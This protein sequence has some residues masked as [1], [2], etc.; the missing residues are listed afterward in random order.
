[1][2]R[3]DHT[4]FQPWWQRLAA[5]W[6]LGQVRDGES[7][8]LPRLVQEDQRLPRF[9]RQCPTTMVAI[10]RLRLLAW[11]KLNPTP[12]RHYF[13]Y[14]P[15][16]QAAYIGANL[17]KIEAGMRSM[18]QL[19]RHL[20]QH[21][22]LIWALGFPL[23]GRSQQAC[24]FDPEA[25]LPTRRHFSHMLRTLDNQELQRLLDGQVSQLKML[26]PAEFGQM[27]SLDTKHILAFVKENN[28]KA[29]IKEGRYDKAQQP[30][31]DSD[32]KLGC[33]R[34]H[35]QKSPTKEGEAASQKVSIGEY[36]WGYASGVVAT[37]I[38]DWGE[39]VLAELTQTFDQADIS[40]FFPLMEAVER[41]LG[42]RPCYGAFDAAFDAFYVY[43]YFDS[44]E[45]DGFAAVPYSEKGGS[46]RRAFSAEGL[47]L[48]AAS[49]PMP[50]KFTFHD[51]T[52][53]L[54]PHVRARYACPLLF[55]E[56]NGQACPVAH[57][58]WAKGGC[59]TTM[60]YTPGAQIRHQLDRQSQL[61]QTVYKQRTATERINSQAVHLGIERPKL[62]NQQ[63]ITNTNTLIYLLINLRA[64]ER[65]LA[66][67]ENGQTD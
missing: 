4:I 12:A 29:Y 13:G 20:V 44:E 51:R 32:C 34:R 42:F 10:S 19:R 40:Y 22:G 66:K 28:P 38:A 49:L 11:D 60:A 59:L 67:L 14:T 21:P 9:V 57:K 17:L 23:Y 64:M 24:G 27:V 30:R 54:I 50:L 15:V 6:P 53:T 46:T 45:H 62:R 35:N 37:K 56:A 25:S 48:C 33:K 31:G 47:P 18:G 39:F 26:L 3:K 55:P 58:R 36:Y 5:L 16:P 1:M 41:R 7:T 61:Y 2:K 63:A 8:R 65:V 43:D 52:T